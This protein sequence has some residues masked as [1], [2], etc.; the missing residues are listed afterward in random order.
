MR[1]K[2]RCDGESEKFCKIFWELNKA[3][4]SST[5]TR[6]ASNGQASKTS[7]LCIFGFSQTPLVTPDG[8]TQASMKR[9]GPMHRRLEWVQSLKAPLAPTTLPTHP[10]APPL[11]ISA[12]MASRSSGS[13]AMTCQWWGR[14]KQSASNGLIVSLPFSSLLHTLVLC[15][16]A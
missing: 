14:P 11:W 3:Q 10:F 1:L 15:N 7:R 12:T 5:S 9:N 16:H 4:A 13:K 2:I 6:D 8:P